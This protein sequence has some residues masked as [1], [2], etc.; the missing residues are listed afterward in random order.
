MTHDELLAKID[1]GSRVCELDSP[2]WS[3]LRAVVKLHRPAKD[4]EGMEDEYPENNGIGCSGCGYNFDHMMW[5]SRYPC[6][7]IQVIEKELI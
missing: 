2:A 7:A 4:N 3:A 1:E 5:E 6:E